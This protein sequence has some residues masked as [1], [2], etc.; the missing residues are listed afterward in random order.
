MVFYFFYLA[1][2]YVYEV[3]Q[4]GG[5][6]QADDFGVLGEHHQF[7]PGIEVQTVADGGR[8]YN[9][10]ALA[11]RHHVHRTFTTGWIYHVFHTIH[12]ST[13]CQEDKVRAAGAGAYMG[14]CRFYILLGIE[15]GFTLI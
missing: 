5:G 9:L 3:A 6:Y 8:H 14:I 7:V 10:T 1:G 2:Q 12:V 13:V 11:E 15:I 4:A